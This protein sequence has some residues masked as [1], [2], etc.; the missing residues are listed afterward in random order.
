MRRPRVRPAGRSPGTEDRRGSRGGRG[1][2]ASAGGRFQPRPPPRSPGSGRDHSSGTGSGGQV[3]VTRKGSRATLPRGRSRGRAR[4]AR[5]AV[6]RNPHTAGLSARP[7]PCE[8]R[9]AL[10]GGDDIVVPLLGPVRRLRSVPGPTARPEAE[11]QGGPRP[12]VARLGGPYPGSSV[13][14]GGP[15][16]IG[17]CIT[18]IPHSAPRFSGSRVDLPVT[19]TG[20]EC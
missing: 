14:A 4:P 7:I 2:R 18:P 3:A 8:M 11:G 15:E 5:A 1:V 13:S 20:A 16:R 17:S 10:L 12:L 6:P 19:K 9:L